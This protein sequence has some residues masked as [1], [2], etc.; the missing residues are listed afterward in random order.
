MTPASEAFA[1]NHDVQEPFVITNEA[2]LHIGTIVSVRQRGAPP[3]NFDNL[4]PIPCGA[5]LR[6]ELAGARACPRV[7]PTGWES[8]LTAA[9]KA[10]QSNG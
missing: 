7:T 2:N 6:Y 3:L 4:V 9:V 5:R 1:E 10:F 8:D